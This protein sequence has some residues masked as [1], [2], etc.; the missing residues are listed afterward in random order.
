[1]PCALKIKALSVTITYAKTQTY[2]WTL[3]SSI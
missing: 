2:K 1:M 3:L